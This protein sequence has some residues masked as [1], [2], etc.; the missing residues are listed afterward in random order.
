M[1]HSTH[2]RIEPLG[3]LVRPLWYVIAWDTDRHAPDSSAPTASPRPPSATAL[4]APGPPNSLT[5]VCPDARPAVART[6][7]AIPSD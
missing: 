1:V 2:R 5:G 3:L 7:T 4:S 6:G